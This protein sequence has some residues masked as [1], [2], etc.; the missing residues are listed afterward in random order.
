M[1]KK[2]FISALFIS[3]GICS[4][5]VLFSDN[6]NS[7]PLQT[8]T[9]VYSAVSYTTASP[10]YTIVNDGFKNNVGSLQAPNQPFNVPA[11]KTTGW[12]VAYN[13]L[14]NDTFLVSTSW[15]DSSIAARRY[16][17]TP[18]VNSITGVS[19]LSWEA[20]APDINYPDGYEI[21]VTNN[22][23]G[24]LSAASFN[25]SDR[26]FSIAD[27]NTPN[28]GEKNKF[29]KR[30]VSLATYAGQ[31]L[32]I[33]FK[34]NSTN[35][36]QLWI[37]DIKVEN[38]PNSTDAEISAGQDIYKY[39]AINTNGSIKFRITNR[40]YGNINS[41]NVNYLVVGTG[42]NIV[43][44]FSIATPMTP[45]ALSDFTFNAPYSVTAPGYY[46]VKVWV[47]D[48]NG[49][50]ADQNQLNDTLV[51]YV[52]IMAT[53]PAKN[54]LVEQFVSSFD[55]YTPDGQD[56][57]NTLTSNTVIA[58]N[59]HDVDSLK[60][61]SV[62]ALINSYKQK[63]STALIDRNYFYDLN[64][65]PVDRNIYGARINLRKPAIVPAS[66]TI[67]N[68]NYNSFTREITFTVNA[69][70]AAEVVG[71]YRINAYITENNVYGPQSDTT[72]N[73]WNQLSF[74]YSVPWSN[75]YQKGYYYA[76]ANGYVLSAKKVYAGAG[77][78][79]QHV[80]MHQHVLTAAP[81]GAYGFVG[82]IP[83]TGGTL[84]QTYSRAYTYTL[85]ASPS[86]YGEFRYNPDNI[87]IVGMVAECNANKNYRTVL[88]CLQDK[89]TVNPEIVSVNELG[90]LN[91]LFSL[92]PNPSYGT[93]NILIP[94]KSFSNPPKIKIT[95]ILGQEIYFEQAE[96][97]FGLLQLNLNNYGNGSYFISLEDGNYK[98]VKK[99]V[100]AR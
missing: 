65:V 21:Y 57:L 82:I 58:V 25:I 77:V 1:I 64:S 9:T 84:A 78:D 81:D 88:N 99:I 14:V 85:P 34:N 96:F 68:K 76:P 55:G 46:K 3:Y 33:A 39:N 38:I 24:T 52:S 26:I 69:T 19:V 5:Q 87:Y 91:N 49:G 35:M 72:Y 67:T 42:N 61:K 47:S 66:V 23:T 2:I 37:D 4:G 8:Y 71:D 15:L 28:G 75:Y 22:T 44:P 29:I 53:A 63:Y 7:Y 50:G 83:L 41:L 12:A 56:V 20:M 95:D 54:V 6:F 62:T 89:L 40:G 74:M 45:F 86:I 10:G 73:G 36:Y 92:Y 16:I 97:K 70:F 51:S 43:E 13:N 48:V 18:P 27:G 79:S 59:I 80:Y 93:L 31:N 32:R 11:L 100:I 90:A 94:E 60:N 30:G 17:V 98:S